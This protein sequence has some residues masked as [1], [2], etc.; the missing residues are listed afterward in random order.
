[1]IKTKFDL[2]EVVYLKT[3]IERKP[4][5]VIDIVFYKRKNELVYM[6][7]SGIDISYHY[8]VELTDNLHYV[9]D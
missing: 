4:R 9:F 5:M 3:D 2:N 7:I 1:M 8:E 6:L